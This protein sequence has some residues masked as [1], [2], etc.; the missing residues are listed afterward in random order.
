MALNFPNSPTDG[1][2]Y[3][4]YQWDA[5]KG[6]WVSGRY[7]EYRP[8]STDLPG[9][10]ELATNA[11]TQTGTDATRAVTPASLASLTSTDARRGLVELATSAEA[12]ARTDAARALTPA[13]FDAAIKDRA[14]QGRIPSSVQVASG[15]SSTAADGTVTFTGASR[16]SL[17]GVFDGL[18]MDAYDIYAYFTGSAAG[19]VYTRM[20]QSGTDRTGNVYN[21]VGNYTSN[22]LGPT[23]ASTFGTNLFGFWWPNTFAFAPAAYGR[24]TMF[25]PAQNTQTQ[26]ILQS[27]TSASDRVLW[28]EYGDATSAIEDGFSIQA[29]SGTLTGMVKVVKIA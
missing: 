5:A 4:G 25:R 6:V 19:A 9:I 8:A 21:Y 22:G 12:I 23:R 15:S 16:V 20:R 24:M 26:I 3:E 29:T 10:V 11:E 1:Q 28:H 14:I 13:T 2:I 27:G 18:G 17:N 7:S